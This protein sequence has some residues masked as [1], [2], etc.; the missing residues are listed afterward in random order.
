MS[1]PPPPSVAPPPL[2]VAASLVAVQGMV[3]VVL[4]V[5]EIADLDAGR[6]AM[7]LSTAVF[8][9]GYGAL[10]LVAG[11]G[12]WR[13]ATWSRGPALITQLIWLGLAWNIREH[14][15]A[16]IAVA[17]VALVVLAGVLHRDSIAALSGEE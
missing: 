3:L 11:W 9:G 4:A 14:L 5:A 12:L 2:T 10:L 7:G 15:V 6:R 8:F 1:D 13:R 17:V 16:A